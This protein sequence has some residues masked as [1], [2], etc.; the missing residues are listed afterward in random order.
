MVVVGILIALQVNNWNQQKEQQRA[1]KRYLYNLIEDLGE[2]LDRYKGRGDQAIFK[3]HSYQHILA[4]LGETP[5]KLHPGEY[6]KPLTIENEIWNKPLPTPP[7]S[8]FLAKSFLWSARDVKPAINRS[9]FDEMIDNGSFSLIK[10][11]ELKADIRAYYKENEWRFGDETSLVPVEAN[12]AWR[13]SLLKSGVLPQDVSNI[14]DPLSL[15]R[16]NMERIGILRTIIRATWFRAQSL[17]IQTVLANELI[18]K[19][20]KEIKRVEE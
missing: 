14:E 6:V 18:Q 5:V 20:E 15:L 10:N 8:L 13:E 9:A 16:N 19:I 4:F 11:N 7:D 3:Y 12:K 17:D 2:D 1:V